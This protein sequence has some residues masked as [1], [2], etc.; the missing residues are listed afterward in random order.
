MKSRPSVVAAVVLTTVV[1]A[2]A[3]GGSEDAGGDGD[4]LAR[5]ETLFT[6]N[7]AACHGEQTMG[8]AAGPP[9]IHQIYEPGHHSD[10]SFQRAVAEGV[11]P[12]HWNFGPMPAMPGLT[13]D[14]VADIIAYVRDLQRDAGIE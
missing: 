8:T 9:L 2:G 10:G 7:C 5:G 13:E 11:E 4:A 1:L 14:Q 12:H 3:C 6:N